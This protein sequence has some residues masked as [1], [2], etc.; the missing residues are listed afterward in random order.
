ML[1]RHYSLLTR[2]CRGN[3]EEIPK[4]AGHIRKA[5][6]ISVIYAAV[7]AAVIGTV[8]HRLPVDN[9]TSVNSTD[10][11]ST[12]QRLLGTMELST[13]HFVPSSSRIYYSVTASKFHWIPLE[14]A[15]FYSK[16]FSSTSPDYHRFCLISPRSPLTFIKDLPKPYEHEKRPPTHGGLQQWPVE[17]GGSQWTRIARSSTE[18]R[19]RPK[20]TAILSWRLVGNIIP[21]HLLMSSDVRHCPPTSSGGHW[22]PPVDFPPAGILLW[23]LGIQVIVIRMFLA[24]RFKEGV[25]LSSNLPDRQPTENQLLINVVAI[26]LLEPPALQLWMN[27]VLQ[28]RL[29]LR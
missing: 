23:H 13:I 18:G 14:F 5:R 15:G 7:E 8:R 3:T 4:N 27:W 28:R 1:K 19:W 12:K 29:Y 16:P 25:W 24:L 11:P 9:R 10:N 6:G 2:N 20:K 21:Q 17:C 26:A 22:C